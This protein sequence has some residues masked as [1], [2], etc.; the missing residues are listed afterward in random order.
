VVYQDVWGLHPADNSRRAVIGGSVV[1]P[2][3]ARIPED[4]GLESLAATSTF[5]ISVLGA[6]LNNGAV[7]PAEDNPAS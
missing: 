1:L 4:P 6:P 2:L 3:L 7:P 5:Q